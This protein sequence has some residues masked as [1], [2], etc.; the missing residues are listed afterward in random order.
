M[1]EHS[2]R[3]VCRCSLVRSLAWAHHRPFAIFNETRV[4]QEWG[5]VIQFNEIKGNGADSARCETHIDVGETRA[6]LGKS[7]WFFGSILKTGTESIIVQ[8]ITCFLWDNAQLTVDLMRIEPTVAVFIWFGFYGS[9]LLAVVSYLRLTAPAWNVC[10]RKLHTHTHTHLYRCGVHQIKK[11]KE[12][13]HWKW[14]T[15]ENLFWKLLH[16]SKAVVDCTV[17]IYSHTHRLIAHGKMKIKGIR[18]YE[19]RGA[20]WPS[21][22]IFRPA[23]ECPLKHTHANTKYTGASVWSPDFPL[24][25]PLLFT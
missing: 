6:R 5:H 8:M 25:I 2:L 4:N 3:F 7:G 17:C 19:C 22:F 1:C 14:I 13:K 12:R 11:E 9:R 10:V 15:N 23:N 18:M 16:L 20:T 24:V 21:D